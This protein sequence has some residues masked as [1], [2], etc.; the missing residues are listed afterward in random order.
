MQSSS[1]CSRNTSSSR[2]T[3]PWATSQVSSP[4]YNTTLIPTTTM[5]YSNHH[6]TLQRLQRKRPYPLQLEEEGK[7][8][9][10]RR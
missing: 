9:D 2:H 5:P 10:K 4:L 3:L 7:A 8:K 1:R 6:H